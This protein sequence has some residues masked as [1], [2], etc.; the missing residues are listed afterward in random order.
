MSEDISQDQLVDRLAE[1]LLSLCA[2][3]T[4]SGSEDAMI[5]TLSQILRA[6]GAEL[7]TLVVEPGRT[8]VLATWGRPRVVFT[9]HLDTVPPY[10]APRRVGR[11][12][13]GRGT[14]DAKG[15][16]VAQLEALRRLRSEGLDGMAW[17]GL[18]GEETDAKGA[19][20][21]PIWKS[22]LADCRLVV[23]GEP[24]QGRCATGQRGYLHLRV[25][26]HGRAAHSGTPERGQSA[27]WP[28]LHWLDRLR[29]DPVRV[30]E[31]L[32]PEVWNL[33][34]IEGG[35]AAN[36]I[37][38][39][40]SAHL[41]C[42]TLPNSDFL[43]RV[44]D[45]APGDAKVEILVN[46]PATRYPRLAGFDYAAMTFGSDLPAFAATLPDADLVLLGPGSIDVAHTPDEFIDLDDLVAG[47]DSL[48]QLGRLALVERSS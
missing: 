34:Q 48:C 19:A 2:C 21:L 4:T 10:I 33:G 14:C 36:V 6:D 30:D 3:D 24:T 38:D 37:P 40:A 46:E 23:G 15:Q 7:E 35:E 32:G 45:A 29:R 31:D 26:T 1:R 18:I 11:R 8:N 22:Q 44:Q 17:L 16:I 13:F 12:V 39:H 28:L 9:T 25:S 20:A 42:R 43:G 47:A 41:L 5:P 27:I